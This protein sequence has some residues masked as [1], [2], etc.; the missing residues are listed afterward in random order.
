ML[1]NMFYEQILRCSLYASSSS[2][3]SSIGMRRKGCWEG[4]GGT[5]GEK[6]EGDNKVSLTVVLLLPVLYFVGVV[7]VVW[8]E[9]N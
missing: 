5:L 4:G 3:L 8:R 1:E 7:P 9:G 6:E 2:P